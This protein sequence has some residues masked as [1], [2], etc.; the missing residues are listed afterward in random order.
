MAPWFFLPSQFG[1]CGKIALRARNEPPKKKKVNH[2]S[3]GWV[4]GD[5]AIDVIG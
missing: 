2:G 1:V 5:G 3:D 4:V